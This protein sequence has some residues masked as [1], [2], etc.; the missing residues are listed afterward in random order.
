[1]ASEN[2]IVEISKDLRLKRPQC[3]RQISCFHVYANYIKLHRKSAQDNNRDT[4]GRKMKDAATHQTIH[5]RINASNVQ[6]QAK[7]CKHIFCTESSRFSTH[8]TY[9]SWFGTCFFGIF[10]SSQLATTKHFDFKSRSRHRHVWCWWIHVDP[11]L[12]VRK[13]MAP[14]DSPSPIKCRTSWIST[15]P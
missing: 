6:L 14:N 13:V 12:H 11:K 15:R 2:D 1:M 10:S 5:H 3:L 7:G 9:R 4:S 8:I